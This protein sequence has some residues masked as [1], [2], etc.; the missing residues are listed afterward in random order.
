MSAREPFAGAPATTLCE[1]RRDLVRV[2]GRHRDHGLPF[3]VGRLRASPCAVHGLVPSRGRR[4]GLCQRSGLHVRARDSRGLTSSCLLQ[5]RG[6][7]G[8]ANANGGGYACLCLCCLALGH[9]RDRG[10]CLAR[11]HTDPVE[12][13]GQPSRVRFKGSSSLRSGLEREFRDGHRLRKVSQVGAG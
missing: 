11:G 5:S 12:G 1:C 2:V 6:E 7:G 4:G 3:L 8:Q 13:V 10:L 9:G